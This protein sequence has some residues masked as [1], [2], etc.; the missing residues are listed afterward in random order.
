MAPGELLVRASKC[1]QGRH[2][3]VPRR[4]RAELRSFGGTGELVETEAQ[5]VGQSPRWSQRHLGVRLPFSMAGS[6]TQRAD[7]RAAPC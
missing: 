1:D 6:R 5:R 3:D 4:L 2:P 7:A